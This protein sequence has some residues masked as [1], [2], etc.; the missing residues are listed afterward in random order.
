MG[1]NKMIEISECIGDL[2]DLI[3]LDIWFNPI[4]DLPESLVKLRNLRSLDLSWLNFSKSFQEKWT[5]LLPW[6]KIEFEAACDCN[7]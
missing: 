7:N 5:K 2:H 4:D 1:K 3:L 6:V